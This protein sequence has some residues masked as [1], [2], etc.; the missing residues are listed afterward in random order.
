V[1]QYF[2]RRK[3]S[4]SRELSGPYGVSREVRLILCYKIF[5]LYSKSAETYELKG[6]AKKLQ[7]P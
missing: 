6:G 4:G 2:R 5:A 3:R 1:T 7:T